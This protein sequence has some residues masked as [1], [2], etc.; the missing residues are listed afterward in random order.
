M[1][2]TPDRF[3]LNEPQRR[4]FAVMLASLEESLHRIEMLAGDDTPDARRLTQLQ[5]DVAD[6]FLPRTAPVVA[7][8]RAQ[9]NELADAMDLG[10]HHQSKAR[11]I[12]ALLTSQMLRV[13]DSYARKLR[14][15]GTV[16]PRLA[17]EL[18]PIMES[19]ERMIAALRAELRGR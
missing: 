1:S 17:P 16:D 19:M 11:T 4:H 2:G 7:A 8:L 14:G 5:H 10:A 13:Q 3:P 15:Y 9:L 18:D 12:G 6:D